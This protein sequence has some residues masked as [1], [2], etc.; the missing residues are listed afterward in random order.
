MFT[1]ALLAVLCYIWAGPINVALARPVDSLPGQ[2]EQFKDNIAG[3]LWSEGGPV[4]TDVL[5]GPEGEC[6]FQATLAAL[7][8]CH[9][10]TITNIVEDIGIGNGEEGKDTDKAKIKLLTKDDEW[11]TFEV[12]HKSSVTG[13]ADGLTNWWPAA[14]KRGV[15]KMG[16]YE[17]V[18]ENTLDGGK[19]SNAL[20]FL[21][22]KEV[23]AIIE[24]TI[25]G[26]WYW[27]KHSNNSRM[28]IGTQGDTS[29]LNDG[30]AYAVMSYSGDGPD[31]ARARLRDPNNGVKW[32]D[33][34][35]IVD[36]IQNI[37]GLAGF[38]S[39]P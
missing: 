39:V 29:K 12:D 36:N 26:A 23:D 10:A 33:L 21:T 1:S 16:G 25:A 2:D 6:W 28:V 13:I 8:K 35:D 22:G 31:N 30:H 4:V 34:K 14:I 15:M 5:Q 17:G 20:R 24:P 18:K 7:V 38:A 27:I 19:A 9:P 32:Y 37:A 3:P 11:K